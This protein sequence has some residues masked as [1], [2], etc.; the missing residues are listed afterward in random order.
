MLALSYSHARKMVTKPK[1]KEK[2]NPAGESIQERRDRVDR[3]SFFCD[4][5]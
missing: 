4:K 3:V 2:M 5:G 1:G